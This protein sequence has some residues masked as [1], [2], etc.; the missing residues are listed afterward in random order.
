MRKWTV[1]LPERLQVEVEAFDDT[2]GLDFALDKAELA[3]TGVAVFRGTLTL[4]GRD[5]ILLEVRYPD[6]FP[7]TRPEVF[8]PELHLDRHQNPYRHNLCLLERST[9]QW[10]PSKTGAWLVSERVPKLLALLEGDAE[11]MRREEAPQGE[12][13]SYYFRAHAGA[14]VLLPEQ[15]LTLPQD[16]RAGTIRLST[17]N[18]EVQE[19]LLRAALTR[20]ETNDGRGKSTVAAADG[21]FAERYGKTAYEGR[22]VRLDSFPDQ[23]GSAEHI[24]AAAREVPGFEMPPKQ[25]VPGAQLRILGAV[26]KEEVRQSEYEDTWLF[27]IEMTTVQLTRQGKVKLVQHYVARG[28]R[29]SAG[30]LAE[31]IP[32]LAGLQSK[33]VALAG[34]GALG[35]PLAIELARAQVGELRILDDDVVEAGT[36]V[37]WPFGVGAVGHRKTAVLNTFIPNEYPYTRVRAFEQPIGFVPASA[38]E[39]P[40]QSEAEMLTDFLAGVDLLIEATAEIGVQQLLAALADEAG[41]PQ[42]YVTA[43]EGGWGGIVARVVPGQTGCWYCLQQRLDDHSIVPPPFAET[44]T[45]QPR[46]CSAPT[47]T[48][49][50]FDALPLIAQAARTATFT[51]LG[52]RAAEMPKDVFVCAQRAE[53]PTE[54]DA[55]EWTSHPLDLHPACAACAARP[56]A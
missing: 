27:A 5:P 42:V 44:G 29:L 24:F 21:A 45:V 7:Y 47:W 43:T 11:Q 16:L 3:A 17:G 4:D 9:R 34:L 19:P 25:S 52:G 28:D 50:S 18:G 53:A 22:W 31:R 37:R 20:V 33:T 48:G 15:A 8:A 49:T 6:S 46:G 38:V 26:C 39:A 14:V 2:E 23:G 1:A 32:G 41:I 54:L 12:P 35:G 13:A 30:D 51:L 36:I 56:A 10:S 55:P 40:P